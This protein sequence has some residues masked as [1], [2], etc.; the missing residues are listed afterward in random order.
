MILISFSQKIKEDALVASARYCSVCHRYKGVKMEVHHIIPVEK[1]GED[2]FENAIALCFDCHSDAGHYY[3]M[4]PRGTKFSPTEL[5]KHKEA[6]NK[7]VKENNIPEY[8]GVNLIHTVYYV[9][10][11]SEVIHEI[12]N[13]DLSKFPIENVIV[14]ANDILKFQKNILRDY[15]SAPSFERINDFPVELVKKYLLKYPDAEETDENNYPNYLYVRIPKKEEVDKFCKKD[16]ICRFLLE[17][18]EDFKNIFK[19]FAYIEECGE[20]PYLQEIL[21]KRDIWACYLFITNIS[22]D[23]L[24]IDSINYK[25]NSLSN[26][27]LAF[28]ELIKNNDELELSLPKIQI[29]PK[30]SIL[31][32]VL[33]L[34][35]P[36]QGDDVEEYSSIEQELDYSEKVQVLSYGKLHKIENSSNF[37]VLGPGIN[38]SSVNILKDESTSSQEVHK[39]D[40]SNLYLI[41]RIWMCGCCPYIFFK[42]ENR[43]KYFCEIF[44][45]AP[46]MTQCFKIIVP[47]G[48]SSFILCEIEYETTFISFIKINGRII[49]KNKKLV[50][51][52]SLEFK[53]NEGDVIDGSGFYTLSFKNIKQESLNRKN[54][55]IKKFIMNN[56]YS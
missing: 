4:H 20:I 24:T 37:S 26:T 19:I 35:A 11:N 45:K 39:F 46:D 10:K 50:K 21:L 12:A 53:V 42:E 15:Q 52:E 49:F 9:T 28:E 56:N 3:A 8:Q 16:R 51:G 18:G 1:G 54:D 17:T 27:Q 36:F 38:P 22:N 23:Y 5:G 2:T 32:P 44:Q 30:K 55:I 40:F 29:A 47:K 14:H 13:G 41:D 25:E 34:L 7:I 31:I 43:T 33:T 6:W 48:V